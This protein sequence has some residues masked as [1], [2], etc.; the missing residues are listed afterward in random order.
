T[1]KEFYYDTVQGG[2]A[3]TKKLTQNRPLEG[4]AANIGNISLLYKDVKKG[5]DAQ[6]SAIYTGKHIV[7]VSP[8]YDMDYWSLGTII[9]DIS[10]EKKLG[11]HFSVYAKLN[12]L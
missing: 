4:Q 2:F 8:Y 9:V 6:I 12:N 3:T 10:A 7:Y 1:T 11:K 5:I